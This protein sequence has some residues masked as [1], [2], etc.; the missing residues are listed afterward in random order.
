MQASQLIKLIKVRK[1]YKPTYTR[2][3]LKVDGSETLL[4]TSNSFSNVI[5]WCYL[6]VIKPHIF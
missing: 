4:G 1:D 2:I 6:V 5:Q 3:T